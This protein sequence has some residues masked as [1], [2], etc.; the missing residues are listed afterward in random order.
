[1]KK[2]L[3]TAILLSWFSFAF[4]QTYQPL[5]QQLRNRYAPLDKSLIPGGILLDQ[6]IPIASPA[7]FRGTLDKNN[8]ADI[9]TFGI[10]FG[11]FR[12]GNVSPASALPAPSIYLEKI[13]KPKGGDTIPVALMAIQYG[14]IRSDAFEQQLLQYS[15]EQVFDIPNRPSSPYNCDT[16]YIA[17]PLLAEVKGQHVVYEFPQE[18]FFSNL[19]GLVPQYAFDAGDGQGWRTITPGQS[20]S[21]L[22]PDAG[23]KT[24]KFGMTYPFGEKM[25]HAKILLKEESLSQKR[26]GGMSWPQHLQEVVHVT[27]STPYLGEKGEADVFFFYNTHDCSPIAKLRRPL[28]IVEGFEEPGVTES[29]PERMFGLLNQVLTSGENL[30][31]N[32]FPQEYD[33]IYVNFKDGSDYVQR[34]AFLI[35]EVIRLVNEKKAESGSTEQNVVIG[36]SMG[37]VVCNYALK[38]MNATGQNHDTRLFFTYDSPLRGANIPIGMQCFIKFLNDNLNDFAGE[39]ISIPALDA[40]WRAINQPI[41]SQLLMY[42]FDAESLYGGT[43]GEP[44]N[45]RKNEFL[46]EMDALG[47]LSMRHV[48]LSNG[49]LNTPLENAMEAGNLFFELSGEKIECIDWN[50]PIILCGKLTFNM[51][52]R[53]TGNNELT[54]IANLEMVLTK[55]AQ[56]PLSAFWYPKVYT[57]PYD[58]I[59][60]ATSNLGLI[61]L[62]TLPSQIQPHVDI[63]QGPGLM[64][65]QHIFIPSFSSVN[66]S[67]PSEF[68][69]PQTCGSV[70]R[71]T[72][73]ETNS[74]TSPQTMLPEF[75]QGHIHLDA[76]I[77]EVLID[78]LVT[79]SPAPPVSPLEVIPNGKLDKYFN[80]AVYQAAKVPSLDILPGS[81]RLSVNNSGKIHYATPTDQ[82]ATYDDFIA[83]TICNAIINVENTAKLYI[84]DENGERSGGLYITDGSIV[85][86]KTGSQLKVF[87]KSRLVVQ[88]GATLIIEPGAEITLRDAPNGA[89][90][91]EGCPKITVEPGGKL[92]IL[93]NFNFKGDGYFEFNPGHLTELP[94]SFSFTGSGKTYRNIKLNRNAVLVKK[95]G[96]LNLLSTRVVFERDA[97]IKAEGFNRVVLQQATFEPDAAKGYPVSDQQMALQAQGGQQVFVVG[98]DFKDF[99]NSLRL[100]DVNNYIRFSESNFENTV[101]AYV[102]NGKNVMLNGV[103]GQVSSFLFDKISTGVTMRNSSLKGSYLGLSNG[104][105]YNEMIKL[106][107]VKMFVMEGGVLSGDEGGYNGIDASEG[108]NNIVLNNGATIEKTLY[109]VVMEGIYANNYAQA[110]PD[111]GLLRMDCARILDCVGAGVHG[112]DIL[113]DIDAGVNSNGMRP[114]EFRANAALVGSGTLGL[115]FDICYISR[116]PSEISANYNFWNVYGPGGN[117]VGP[118]PNMYSLYRRNPNANNCNWNAIAVP[119]TTNFVASGYDSSCPGKGGDGGFAGDIQSRGGLTYK[120]CF[121]GNQALYQQFTT[122]WSA[123]EASHE[124]AVEADAEPDYSTALASFLGISQIDSVTL[125]PLASQCRHYNAVARTFIKAS[126]KQMQQQAQQPLEQRV[127]TI[128]AQELARVSPNPATGGFHLSLPEGNN[129]DIRISDVNGKV[130]LLSSTLA[131]QYVSTQDW[132]AGIYTIYYVDR[133]DSKRQG[134]VRV[135]VQ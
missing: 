96:S 37:G 10:L 112:T 66:A 13:S 19:E 56:T 101:G 24:L 93:G 57:K 9:N 20:V 38:H 113:L 83:H 94:A 15:G 65:K 2:V 109:G 27:A 77:S 45:I 16:T 89:M 78:E 53:A 33:L 74:E 59:S 5:P 86:L 111:Y 21:I 99:K 30:T 117:S 51:Q 128:T 46:A 11:Q 52:M 98:C 23:E 39:G 48:A 82:D 102:Y 81:G 114:N 84:G 44:I 100:Y 54:E 71:C 130:R 133:T 62:N 72:L 126:D 22:Y 105:S 4:A 119:L 91:T 26:S 73:S 85:R 41:A 68:N 88:S 90:N 127:H 116:T 107:D 123:W 7:L 80:V 121:V 64:V 49:S 60:G 3:L 95:G 76:R 125:S 129:W 110:S 34:N 29:T 47:P 31:D 106:R 79:N 14:F 75:N 18:L 124:L 92:Q 118:T 50:N 122:A 36:V 28:I 61:G 87:A 97:S 58:V 104:H 70:S 108:Q 67:E 25:A 43:E 32:L 6:S 1:M 132:S 8:Y 35:E 134:Q 69:N 131:Q 120:D 63:L 42:R 12:Q 115:I 40:G 17:S 135:L 55:P 103:E